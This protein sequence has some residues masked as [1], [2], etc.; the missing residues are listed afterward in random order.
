MNVLANY[1][2]AAVK[3]SSWPFKTPTEFIEFVK[4]NLNEGMELGSDFISHIGA[5]VRSAQNAGANINELVVRGAALGTLSK[6]GFPHKGRAFLSM[7]DA[8]GVAGSDPRFESL[9]KWT[10]P[11]EYQEQL[12]AQA[13]AAAVAPPVAQSRSPYILPAV[14]FFA[15]LVGLGSLKGT[16]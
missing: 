6:G 14:I 12:D 5:R 10:H 8:G 3:Y 13:A 7:F 4:K 1:H 16:S 2:Y 9:F 15:V 11:E